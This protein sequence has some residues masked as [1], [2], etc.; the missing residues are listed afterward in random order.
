M[1]SLF[2]S[3][4]RGSA[5]A[6]DKLSLESLKCVRQS[7]RACVLRV[8]PLAAQ[9]RCAPA[10]HNRRPAPLPPPLAP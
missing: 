10:T 7:T 6:P 9:A 2:D 8:W 5:R 3:L 4:V 1:K